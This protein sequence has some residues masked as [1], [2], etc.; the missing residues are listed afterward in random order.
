MTGPDE[1]ISARLRQAVAARGEELIELTASLVRERSLLG[2]EEGA[3]R[4]VAARM[5]ALGF[6]AERI[7]IELPA[8]D[9]GTWG[10]PPGPY[11]GRTCV[12]GRIEGSG[13]GRSL[14]LS[15]HVDVVPVEAPESWRHD[16]WG[17]E[18][19]E[20]RIWGRG[21]GDMKAGIAAYLI[22]VEA[23]LEVCGAPRGDLIFSSVIE[24]ECTGNGM[25]AV[26][27]AGYEADATLIGEPSG[28]RLWHAGAGVIWAR[29]RARSAGAHVALGVGGS[30]SQ[31]MIAALAALEGLERRLNR[32]E[33]APGERP[34]AD[35]VFL[36][37]HQRPFRL[38]AG[39][40]TGGEW[41]SSEPVAVEVRVRL[42][43]GPS[44]TP[45]EAQALLAAAVAAGAPD[46]EV[47]F[48]GF[49]AVAYCD[50]LGHDLARV[51]SS[52]HER[53]R[54]ASPEPEVLPGTT[55]ARSVAGPAVCYGPLAGA[56]HATDEW[57]DIDSVRDVATT[58]ALTIAAWHSGA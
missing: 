34:E 22:G 48:E 25:K 47:T 46:V 51:L 53:V 16:P 37:A 13:G 24:E 9:D 36:D 38:N 43:F 5:E 8:E 7:T 41:P 18:V 56:I 33:D 32:L 14:H 50:P 3:Q 45:S 55:D 2:E 6:P 57:V 28:L 4:L 40:F 23:F 35:A 11:E 21:A 26:L 20:G 42:G 44:L 31:R 19:A 1:A 54:G 12:A 17:G 29:L 49:R 10:Y 39:T 52:A 58:I 30:S 15:G 27:A